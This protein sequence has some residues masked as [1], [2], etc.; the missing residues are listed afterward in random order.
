MRDILQLKQLILQSLHLVEVLG[1][2]RVVLS[3][4]CIECTEAINIS[5]QGR[6][7]SDKSFHAK[8]VILSEKRM[9]R[10]RASSEICGRNHRT[11]DKYRFEKE[12]EKS[13]GS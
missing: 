9:V 3:T 11:A 6:L 8:G 10:S 5:C 4:F 12:A 7:S 1:Q 13:V 2:I